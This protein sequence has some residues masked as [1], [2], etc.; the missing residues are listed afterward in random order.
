M[1]GD[2][3]RQN[4][5]LIIF[6]DEVTSSEIEFQ[7]E[8][9]DLGLFIA[10]QFKSKGYKPQLVERTIKK[11]PKESKELGFI[12]NPIGFSIDLNEAQIIIECIEA[13]LENYGITT[14]SYPV[15]VQTIQEPNLQ[16]EYL[17]KISN[18][19]KAEQQTALYVCIYLPYLNN[20]R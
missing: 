6:T 11:W 20:E 5:G 19:Q 3:F 10:D 2:S 8:T 9:K 15:Q 14:N 12:V 18:H 17:I 7:S 1:R 16:D 13:S 4:L